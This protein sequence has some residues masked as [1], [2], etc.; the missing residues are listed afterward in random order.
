MTTS[1][2][3]ARRVV[4]HHR[5]AN[6]AHRDHRDQHAQPE[7]RTTDHPQRPRHPRPPAPDQRTRAL[8]LCESGISLAGEFVR[9]INLRGWAEQSIWGSNA[10][11]ECY[12]VALWR[13]NDRTDAPRIEFSVYLR[14]PTMAVLNR[15]VADALNLR[16]A[17]V[18]LALTTYLR[19]L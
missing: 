17:E 2:L 5:D 8:T 4:H 18:I 19:S 10:L 15:L 12:W 1:A 13:D 3:R 9:D 7:R 11:R 16:E 6:A 14:I